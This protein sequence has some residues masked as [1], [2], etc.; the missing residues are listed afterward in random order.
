MVNADESIAR[1]PL[2][3][4]IRRAAVDDAAVIAWHRVAMFRDMGQVPSEE[5]AGKLLHESTRA[6]AVGLADGSYVGWLALAQND[7]VVAGAGAHVA[8][9]AVRGGSIPIGSNPL[10]MIV[11]STYY[12]AYL[13]G[14]RRLW[15]SRRVCR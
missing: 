12:S 3:L 13:M 6:L 15:R 5:L 7:Q 9:A 1:A 10:T 4:V 2:G 8:P 11:A 14:V